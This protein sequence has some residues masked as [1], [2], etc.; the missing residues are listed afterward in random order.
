MSKDEIA[1]QDIVKAV[2]LVIEFVRALLKL[3]SLQFPSIFVIN[4]YKTIP[5]TFISMGA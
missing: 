1:L 5:A 2:R 4:L 3:T